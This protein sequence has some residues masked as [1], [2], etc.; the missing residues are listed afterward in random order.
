MVAL[1]AICLH[2]SLILV[3]RE[4]GDIHPAALEMNEE[5]DVVGHQ[6]AQRQHLCGEEVGPCQQR[7][8]GPNEG[9]PSSRALAL[10]RWR[11]TVAPQNITDRLIGNLVSQI[12]Q[13]PA[14]RS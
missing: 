7:Y 6:P 14:S 4:P 3:N 8:M 2:P 13:R 5:Q 11:Q 1:R 12:G 10:R 9:R